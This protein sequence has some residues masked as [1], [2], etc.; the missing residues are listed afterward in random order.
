[1][2]YGIPIDSL[3]LTMDGELKKKNHMEFLKIRQE[4]E[5]TIGLP[6]ILLPTHRD[7]L[8]GRGKPFREHLGNLKM[9]EMIDGQ[10]DHYE[11]LSTKQK[12]AAIA[13][14]FSAVK[15]ADGRFLK[16]DKNSCWVE[17][18]EKAAKEKVSHAFRTRL[19]ISKTETPTVGE[20][21]IAQEVVSSDGALSPTAKKRAVS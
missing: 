8:F 14:M 4:M 12:T 21:S 20:P 17:V 7:V 11:S 10:L 9:F 2:T 16:Q 19:R 6:R 1:M 3:P 15:K 5:A 13:A 18:D